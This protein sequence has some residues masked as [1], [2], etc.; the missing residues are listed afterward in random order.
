[1]AKQKITPGQILY[2]RIKYR[3]GGTTGDGSWATPG[4][5]NT[6]VSGKNTFEQVGVIQTSASVDVTVTFPETFSQIPIVTATA[7]S[8][9]NASTFV[10]IQSLTVSGMTVRAY[11]GSTRAQ[12][13]VAWRAVGQ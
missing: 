10:T 9:N 11:T 1:M 8:S 5:S 6:D 2:G 3:Q 4:T 7:N 12:E 13:S